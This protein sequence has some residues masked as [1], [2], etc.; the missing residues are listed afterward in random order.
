MLGP[1]LLA[2]LLACSSDEGGRRRRRPAPETPPP[3]VAVGRGAPRTV[4]LV[5]LDTVRADRTSVC[6]H[7]RPTTPTLAGL[8]ARGATVACRATSPAPWTHPAHASLFTGQHVPEHGAVWVDGGTAL[9]PH[10]SVRPL[11]DE[12]VTLAEVY[13]DRGY[14]TVALVAN[15]IVTPAS[16]LLQ[17]FDTTRLTPSSYGLRGAKLER[18]AAEVVDSL[19]PTRPLFLFVNLYDAHDPYPEVPAGHP[20][21]P[22]QPRVHLHPNDP[23]PAQDY[24]RFLRGT[25]AEAERGPYLRRLTDG[26]DRGV[27]VADHNL[28]VL[29]DR[30]EASGWLGDDVRLVVTSDHG[31]ALGEHG[32]LRHGGFVDEAMVTVPLLLWEPGRTPPVPDR[33]STLV[34]HRWLRD[35]VLGE[36]EVVATSERNDRDLLV[37]TW[38]A[39]RWDGPRKAVCADLDRDARRWQVDL[40]ADPGELSPAALGPDAGLDPWCEAAR[41]LAGRKDGGSDVVTEALKAAGYVE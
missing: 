20:F 34:A 35:G 3:V 10:A 1:W 19:D 24:V 37:G 15:L 33:V 6:G 31:E 22:A 17:G 23:D 26:Y 16:G 18:A 5:V 38:A 30:L 32:R 41:G 4:I 11:A 39:A 2:L 28:G 14:Q 36:A 8:V 29:L 25:M 40:A 13:R 27:E 21:L 12:A 9:N 7:D